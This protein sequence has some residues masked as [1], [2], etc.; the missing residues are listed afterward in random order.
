[1]REAGEDELRR[2]VASGEPMDKAGSYAVQGLGGALVERVTGCY[3]TVVGLPLCLTAECLRACGF[4]VATPA[5]AIDP[6]DG[7]PAAG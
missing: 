5:R 7:A 2:Y 4:D 6:H 1:M 3:N